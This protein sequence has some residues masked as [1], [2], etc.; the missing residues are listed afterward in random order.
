MSSSL[1]TLIGASP[2]GRAR[3]LLL[4]HSEYGTAVI[5]QGRPIPW[6][7]LAELTG[8]FGQLNGLLAPDT[9]WVDVDALY[10]AHLGG[11]DALVAAMGSRTRTGY[12]LRTLLADDEGLDLVLRTAATLSE[13]SR[14]PV[15]LSVPSPARWL[16]QTHRV[17]GTPLEVVDEDGADKASMYLAEWLGRLG[18]LAVGLLLLDARGDG[19]TPVKVEEDLDGYTSITNVADHFGWS[20]A[21]RGDEAVA[22]GKAQPSIG[23]VTDSFWLEGA[24]L[25]EAA[26]LIAA[27]PAAASPER[28]LEQLTLLR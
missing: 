13:A 21:M 3:P 8:Y 27:I 9:T 26:A 16:A 11:R 22:V 14:R 2:S 28:V 6:T 17:A 25:P 12:A 10:S 1:E 7:D 24:D 18:S 19:E 20:L 5:R 4:D 23:L 15:V